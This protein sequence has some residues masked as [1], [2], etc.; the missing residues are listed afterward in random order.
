MI[1]IKLI[2]KEAN[3]QVEFS[4]TMVFFV[5]LLFFIFS[6]FF[7]FS[8]SSFIVFS[9]LPFFL[10]S[11]LLPLLFFFHLSLLACECC[12]CFSLFLFHLFDLVN[13]GSKLTTHNC[14]FG[15]IGNQI[16]CITAASTFT[17]NRRESIPVSV[18]SI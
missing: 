2:Q 4:F 6:P 9:S 17:L 10:S 14:Y 15:F 13:K 5:S 3:T 8:S 7:L 11:F 16:I 1:Q 12:N 18:L